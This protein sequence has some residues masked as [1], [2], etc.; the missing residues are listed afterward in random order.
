MLGLYSDTRRRDSRRRRH[1]DDGRD[2]HRCARAHHHASLD[3][4]LS[5]AKAGRTARGRVALKREDCWPCCPTRSFAL[6][7]PISRSRRSTTCSATPA[8]LSSTASTSGR[9]AIAANDGRF[10]RYESRIAIN[11]DGRP[12]LRDACVLED[13]LDAVSNRM[14]RFDTADDRRAR[15]SALSR[16]GARLSRRRA[17][18]Q[19]LQQD[20]IFSA[21]P[22][23]GAGVLLRMASVGV[24]QGTRALRR[25]LP[26]FSQLLGD[27]PW[28]RKW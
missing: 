13:G 5:L 12:I 18:C 8:S 15:R 20:L 3:K 2:R 25:H 28:S 23:A 10:S 17:E 1:S 19:W 24:E 7:M 11:L 16:R 4:G 9:H 26:S 27:D 21:A 14:G 22:I 6:P